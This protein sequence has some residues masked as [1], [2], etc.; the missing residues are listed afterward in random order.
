MLPCVDTCPEEGPPHGNGNGRERRKTGIAVP[1]G[2]LQAVTFAALQE[3]TDV[4]ALLC[5]PAEQY[6]K[7]KKG[8]RR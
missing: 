4:S 6:L 5:R 3:P 2:L 1:D 8:S 7:A